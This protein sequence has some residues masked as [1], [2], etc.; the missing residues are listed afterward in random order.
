MVVDAQQWLEC[1]QVPLILKNRLN[2][3]DLA[4]KEELKSFSYKKKETKKETTP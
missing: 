1:L 2:N 4:Q 3:K